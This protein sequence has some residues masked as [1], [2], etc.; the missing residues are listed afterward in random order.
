M[1][2]QLRKPSARSVCW[3]SGSP[4]PWHPR[5]PSEQGPC[6]QIRAACQGAGFVQ[7]AARDGIGL[8]IHCMMPIMQASAQPPT[9]RRPL[10]KVAPQLV[11]DCKASHARFGPPLRPPSDVAEP[12]PAGPPLTRFAL[13]NGSS[14]R[15]RWF[16]SPVQDVVV[17]PPKPMTP[18][19]RAAISALPPED[20][21]ETGPAKSL[22]PQLRR[23]MID[24]P[25]KEPT[26]TI[27]V[28]T[29]RTYLYL[30][31]G[32]GKAMR[33]GIGVGR[34]GFTWSGAEKVTKMAEWPDWHPPEEMIQR[35][36]YLPRFMAGGE[37]NPLGARALYLG[38]TLYRIHGT[39][40]PSTIG[41]FVSSGCIRLT[42]RGHRGPL[43][44][45]PAGHPGGRAAGHLAW[46][47]PG[48]HKLTAHRADA[49]AATKGDRPEKPTAT[50][51]P[52]CRR[53]PPRRRSADK[54][55]AATAQAPRAP[56]PTAR[57]RRPRREAASKE[58]T[59]A[60]PATPT[61][62][63]PTARMPRR[64]EAPTRSPTAATA[65]QRAVIRSRCP[66]ASSQAPRA[67]VSVPLDTARKTG[68]V[69]ATASGHFPARLSEIS[70]R[71]CL[72]DAPLAQPTALKRAQII[73]ICSISP[74]WNRAA[75]DRG[76]GAASNL[77]CGAGIQILHIRR[78]LRSVYRRASQRCGR[79]TTTFHWPRALT[80]EIVHM[81]DHLLCREHTPSNRAFRSRHKFGD[82]ASKIDA[83]IAITY[84]Q[85][86][87]V[88]SPR[89]CEFNSSACIMEAHRERLAVSFRC[90][91][92]C[93]AQH[94]VLRHRRAGP[95][96]GQRIPRRQSGLL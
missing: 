39:N 91:A 47:R 59:G 69:R 29:Q 95:R 89:R 38:Q 52:L 79:A 40:Q 36:P 96:S 20:R 46:F 19:Q 28:D 1:I 62:A 74:R 48:N 30:V 26:G 45:G 37:G 21:P 8:Q 51:R 92:G 93:D 34:E 42:N 27:V 90:R 81:L 71:P 60:I 54:A 4:C 24:Y 44:Q 3:S 80:L 14:T 6:E 25:S 15:D 75:Q 61:A 83:T 13:P 72:D 22:P 94:F 82:N 64:N 16:L 2:R 55:P 12:L 18:E 35:Q 84:E 23:T 49:A 41:T 87:H 31:L 68:V 66:P 67:D 78:R 43:R 10:P 57:A 76:N 7:G 33:Y 73:V 53:K 86:H 56:A 77:I 32:N 65:R 5:R 9:A 88:G 63:A 58:T 70:E 85:C 17:R 50:P 11:A